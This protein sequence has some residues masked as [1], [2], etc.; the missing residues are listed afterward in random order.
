M[1]RWD[2]PEFYKALGDIRNKDILEIGVGTGRIAK[3]VLDMSCARFV[4]LDISPSTI[5]RAR[6]NLSNY[7][8]IELVVG[9]IESF[10]RDASFDVTYSVLTLM[11]VKHKKV[12]LSNMVASLKPGG[13]LVISISYD[14]DLLDY[15]SRK[16]K[17]FST[18]AQECA[19]WLK[20]FG[21]EVSPIIDLVDSFVGSNGEKSYRYGENFSSL[22]IATKTSASRGTAKMCF[23][24]GISSFD[25]KV[26]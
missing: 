8:N 2:A 18:T 17:L 3:N 4:G 7:E 13:R 11:H 24:T 1:S 22:V 14:G 21:C 19:Q 10:R 25:G 9:D 5:E 6:L 20:E 23:T 15:G 12:A 26:A 16:V